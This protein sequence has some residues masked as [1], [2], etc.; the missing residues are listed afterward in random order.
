[1]TYRVRPTLTLLAGFTLL[2][3]VPT[4]QAQFEDG[5]IENRGQWPDEVLYMAHL[6][7]QTVW[8]TREA[9]VFDFFD[10]VDATEASA[11]DAPFHR[12]RDRLAEPEGRVRGH[13]VELHFEGGAVGVVSPG[14]ELATRL[15]YFLGDDPSR[16][17]SNVA[18][19]D[20]VT[21]DGLYDGVALR[22]RREGGVLA[23]TFEADDPARLAPVRLATASGEALVNTG[24]AMTVTMSKGGRPLGVVRGAVGRGESTRWYG[25]SVGAGGVQ[26]DLGV[27]TS[28]HEAA[29]AHARSAGGGL[30]FSTLLGGAA[31]EGV[32]AVAIGAD[33][34]VTVAGSTTSPSVFPTTSGAY[35]ESYNGESDVFVARLSADGTTLIYST[36][37]GG[38]DREHGWAVAVATD[39]SATVAGNT[40]SPDFP[41][42]SGAY[43]ET[44]SDSYDAFVAR[45]SADG[46]SLIYSTLLG[47]ADLDDATI[48]ATSTDGSATVAGLTRSAEFPTTAGAYDENYNGDFDA[49]VT[50]LSAD[51]TSLIYST[52]LGGADADRAYGVVVAADGS[53]TVVGWVESSDFPTTTGA[54]DENYNGDFDAF[55]TRLSADGTS[56][57]YSTFLGGVYS[58][59]AYGVATGT[60]GS[61][62][63]AGFTSSPDFPATSGA[64]DETYNGDGD[65]FVTR[66]S[67]DGTSLLHSTFLGGTRFEGAYS[68]DLAADGSATVAG[69][70]Y[71]ADFPTTNGAFDESFNSID[72]NDAFVTRLSADGT[73]L[74][75]STFLGAEVFD[76]ARA[77]AVGTDGSATAAGVTWSGDFPT[78]SGA[79]DESYNGGADAFVARL[80]LTGPDSV[81]TLPADPDTSI[82]Y[83]AAPNPFHR[84]ARLRLDIADEQGVTVRVYDVTGREVARLL[85]SRLAPGVYEVVLD[86]GLLPGGVYLV[87]ATGEHFVH[88]QLVTRIP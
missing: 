54:Y 33:G 7:G 27:A 1:M 10:I 69:G 35:D 55:V 87:R 15:N 31:G 56:L 30:V 70:T 78:T 74:I 67:A 80:Q 14:R 66:L 72:E 2:A 17:A 53:A 51:G 24:D 11:V 38:T 12:R 50:R 28:G 81:V 3:I 77:V 68:L 73:N 85:D 20:E 41:T 42:T 32:N 79:F 18:V 63:V 36:F 39:G 61:A 25:S 37:L 75:Y 58:D 59:Q 40:R 5:F 34:S 23:M 8:V 60:D 52:F 44:Y 48:L 16:H 71:S 22:L 29:P 26:V 21:L 43:D 65:A 46:S 13:V 4:A 9:L 6:P 49:F 62:T 82:L 19:V 88:T 45:L 64:Y 86:A 83:G 47:E 57:I 76:R 84:E